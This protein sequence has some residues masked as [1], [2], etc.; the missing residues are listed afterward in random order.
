[1]SVCVCV[2][3]PIQFMPHQQHTPPPRLVELRVWAGNFVHGIQHVWE[4]VDGGARRVEGVLCGD[5]PS[6]SSEVTCT[7]VTLEHG[8]HIVCVGGRSG[9]IID[10]LKIATSRGRT[11]EFGSSEGGSPWCLMGPEEGFPVLVALFARTGGHVH[12]FLAFYRRRLAG[13]D[14][15]DVPSALHAGAGS[16]ASAT[17][18]HALG[19]VLSSR[20]D[21]PVSE[22]AATFMLLAHDADIGAA[23]DIASK[24]RLHS[25]STMSQ[26]PT[27]SSRDGMGLPRTHCLKTWRWI[28]E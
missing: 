3:Y 6:N 28:L 5:C 9:S 24:N 1:M 15:L 11:F 13:E 25:A 12:N 8:E 16:P 26:T 18:A 7:R 27:S 19:A 17:K 23:K 4:S 10:H 21:F 20:L 2:C 22:Q 14:P